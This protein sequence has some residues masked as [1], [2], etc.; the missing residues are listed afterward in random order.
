MALAKGGYKYERRDPDSVKKRAEQDGGN[1]DSIFKS[2]TDTFRAKQGTN[3]V[4]FLPPTW[5]D[6]E[7]YGFDVWV[8]SYVG[9]DNGSY[10]CPK[11]MLE[12][13]CPIC[14]AS[15]EAA[16]AGEEDDAKKLRATKKVAA[17]IVDRDDKKPV[18]KIWLM[19]WSQDK[20]I[21]TLCH[22]E[23]TGKVLMLDDTEVG[24]DLSFKRTGQQLNTRYMGY[25]VDRDKTP[26]L[27]SQAAQNKLME[28]VVETP[29]PDTL[30]YKDAKYLEKVV[31]GTAAKKDPDE[32]DDD[33]PARRGKR[34]E[35]EDEEVAPTR[36]RAR[37]EPDE[38]D[39]PAPRRRRAAEAEEEEPEEPAP[40]RRRAEPEPEEEERPSRR[41]RAEPEEEAGEEP[42][43]RRRRAEP[44][45]EA[46][47][48]PAP[49]RRRAA[50]PADE[51]EPAP[52][53]RRAE[54]EPDEEEPAP[55]RR[56]A[57]PEEEEEPAHRRRARAE[58]PEEE[59]PPPRRRRG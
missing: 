31:S 6:P 59:D 32:E 4:R 33:R 23:K 40:R 15:K 34:A 11:K 25:V 26:L 43:P 16:D 37:A 2:G 57:E 14:D 36:R 42:A 54:P 3:T 35:P 52:R 9:A 45:E 24:Y 44:E 39:E 48:D 27:E 50:E 55:R 41:R 46:E 58:P 49:R 53:R 38:P 21:S 20:E 22:S 13:H 17:Y 1:F 28:I 12:K 7:H 47:E 51:E 10:L 30:A 18:P 29:I 19:S 5:E 56:R 8:H